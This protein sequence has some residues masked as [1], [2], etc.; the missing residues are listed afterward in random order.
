MVKVDTLYQID[1]RLREVKGVSKPFGGVSVI[2]LGDP[3]QLRP[4]RGGY[5]WEEPKHEKYRRVHQIEP[6]WNQYLPIILR[7]NHRQGEDRD[8]SDI[9]NRIRIG[10]QDQKDF[11][12]LRGRVFPRN[13]P[14]IPADS[15]HIFATNMEVN[16]MN[17][18]FLD[19]LAG[20][21]FIVETEVN[22][23]VLKKFRVDVDPSGFIHNTSLL[24]SFHFKIKSKVMLTTN[25]CTVDGLTNGAFGQILGLRKNANGN[26]IEIHVSFSN[27]SV[28]KET[29]QQYPH[30]QAKYGRPTIPITRFEAVFTFGNKE[31]DGT[32]STASAF[33]FPLK[34]AFSVTSHKVFIVVYMYI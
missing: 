9:L 17:Q 18:V 8:F 24:K 16:T 34:L 6:I 28:G 4:V 3:L 29:A 22:H 11:D 2:L 27:P 25:L 14:R 15:I 26:I 12:V 30:L 20:E 33:G 31:T 21:E 5:P 32:R 7:T 10:E 13:D 1:V 23:P 19:K